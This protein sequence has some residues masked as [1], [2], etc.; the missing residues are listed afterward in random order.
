MTPQHLR[1]PLLTGTL[2]Q[3]FLRDEDGSELVEFA[4]SVSLLLMVMIGIMGF[5]LAVYAQHFVALAAQSGTRYASVRGASWPSACTSATAT[6]CITNA[7]MVQ[8]Y[9]QSIA[10]GG[11]TNSKL[12]VQT[13]WPATTPAG[14]ACFIVA[15]NSNSPGCMV[16][17]TVK[18]PFSFLLPFLPTNVMNFT[19]TGALPIAQ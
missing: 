6:S 8:S 17:V 3:S 13:T 18:Y 7:A 2:L 12:I 10:P 9:V 1:R 19:S 5:S 14:G 11:V 16:K 15:G 4:L